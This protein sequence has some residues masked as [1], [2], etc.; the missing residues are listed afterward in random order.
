MTDSAIRTQKVT[1]KSAEGGDLAARLDSPKDRVRAYA[2]FA[3]CFTCSKDVFAASRISQA[4]AARGIAVLRFDFT[5]LG[6]SDGDFANTNFT[7]NVQ[8][9]IAAA[10]FLREEYEAPALLI[11]HSLGG[12]AVLAAAHRMPEARAVATIAA[13][14]SAEHVKAHLNASLDEIES[15]GEAE[16]MLSGRPFRIRK[17]FL[18]DIEG[19]ALAGEIAHMKKALIV[20]HA[21]RDEIVSIDNAT[22]IFVAAKHPK[23]FV[24]LDDAD[25]LLSRRKDAVYVADVMSAWASRFI[26]EQGEEA[27]TEPVENGI[28][29]VEETRA[30]KLQQRVLVRGHVLTADEPEDLGGMDSGP[31]PYDLLLAALGTC[32]S[33]TL[34]MYAD[35]KKWPLERVRVD[36]THERVHAEDCADCETGT[37]MIEVL[38]RDIALSG[39]LDEAQREKLLEIAD[40]C[41]VHRTITHEMHI[42]TKIVG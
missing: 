36:L 25:H 35:R 32:T 27:A 30:G 7:S 37:G 5:G 20:F 14:S 26:D 38:T 15:A 41:P 6:D 11:G 19:R 12:A 18:D 22:D 21:P 8:D 2:L 31:T 34:R 10:D 24:S 17:Q 33:M 28:V 9:L 1:F 39:D 13:P 16:V 3:H 42:P 23:S 29:R 4:L 40:K